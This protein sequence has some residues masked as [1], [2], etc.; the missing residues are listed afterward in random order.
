MTIVVAKGFISTQASSA[1]C[2]TRMSA[3]KTTGT[4]LSS[5]SDLDVGLELFLKKASRQT[6]R[7]EKGEL[8]TGRQYLPPSHAGVFPRKR[9]VRYNFCKISCA[10]VFSFSSKSL[11]GNPHTWTAK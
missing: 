11:T 2:L 10:S 3:W 9:A 5:R 6:V 4:S 1:R 8:P 7:R